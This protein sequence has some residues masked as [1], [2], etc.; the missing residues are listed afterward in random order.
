MYQWNNNLVFSIHYLF[1]LFLVNSIIENLLFNNL[2]RKNYNK[3]YYVILYN[4]F[5]SL[6]DKLKKN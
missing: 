5:F 3:F 1:K 4:M 2:L 6:I